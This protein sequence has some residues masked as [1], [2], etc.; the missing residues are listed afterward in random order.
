M[1]LDTLLQIVT[2]VREGEEGFHEWSEH[3]LFFGLLSE[4][5]QGPSLVL[6]GSSFNCG[7]LLIKSIL[8]PMEE[9]D[10]VKPEDMTRWDSPYESWSCGLVYGGG[11]PPRLEY[12]EPLS[13][14]FPDAFRSGQQL[15]FG[16]SFSGLT[17]NKEYYEIG[18]FL[19]H[20]HDLH[21]TP[22][23]SAWCRLD[24]NGDVEDVISW[25]ERAGRSGY[26]SATCIAINRDVMEMQM[27]A[28]GTALVQMF[29]I[30]CIRENFSG[31]NER[32]ESA[33][34]GD[35][36]NLYFRAHREGVNGGWIRGVQIIR[37]RFSSEGYGKYLY[38]KDRG[39]KQY[40][41]FITQDWK[42]NRI[43]EVSCAP[44]AMASYFQPESNLPFEISPVF[45]KAAVL[46]KYKADPE[47]Y[48]LK[49][50]TISCRNAWHLQTYDVNSAGQVHTYL[51]YMG[52]LP[53]SEQLYWKSFNEAPKRPVSQRALTTDFKG[54]WSDHHDPLQELQTC[55]N[56]LHRSGVAWFTLRE[57]ALVDQLHC[58]LTAADK[59][60]NDT[61]VALAKLV[62]EGLERK[63][64]VAL[65]KNKGA[66][67]DP[68]WNSISWVQ[69]AVKI[70][71]VSKEIADEVT[72]PLRTVQD[73]RTKLG[74]HSGGS[75]AARLRAGLIRK[76]KTPRAH[77]E[78]IC[79]ELL[80]SLNHLRNL[81][82]P[83]SEPSIGETTKRSDYSS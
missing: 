45:F 57:P 11:Q 74:A 36:L 21:W 48:A 4:Q 49:H 22:E 72:V 8:V 15:V 5:L 1:C 2:P 44:D 7:S 9:L 75:E 80:S 61:L 65:A 32:K 39:P 46:D 71:G 6:Y 76:Y 24:E 78:H 31:W 52:D 20:A 56:D 66:T 67:G 55:L 73:L 40:A 33:V 34:Q 29:D 50:R 62:V 12:S 35:G 10:K 30:A 58:P 17:E 19:T 28:T 54:E 69:E 82:D 53:Y 79:D 27:S 43:T 63:Y 38:D 42:N 41:S 77:I 81:F 25:S 37:P 23:R 16:R 14:S 70:S 18:Q 83:A 68:K 59:A 47:K 60:W 3:R 51:K 13:K 26:G 64:F